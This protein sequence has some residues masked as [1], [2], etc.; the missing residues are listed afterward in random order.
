[1]LPCALCTARTAPH[2]QELPTIQFSSVGIAQKPVHQPRLCGLHTSGLCEALRLQPR[3]GPQGLTARPVEGK[4][5]TS[6]GL[7][8]AVTSFTKWLFE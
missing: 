7:P 5:H 6:R 3:W 4:G 2:G 1:M 8:T